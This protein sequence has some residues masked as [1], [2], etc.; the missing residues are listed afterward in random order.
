M[1]TIQAIVCLWFV[2]CQNTNWKLVDDT[3][4]KFSFNKAHKLSLDFEVVFQNISIVSMSNS[5]M[6]SQ[7]TPSWS[8]ALS[9]I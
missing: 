4:S 9:K 7:T 8:E 2:L 6:F 5:D 3:V 1:R